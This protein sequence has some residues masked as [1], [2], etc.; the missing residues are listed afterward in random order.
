MQT[1]EREITELEAKVLNVIPYGI[2]NAT[3]GY[4]LRQRLNG[5]SERTFH[6]IIRSLRMKQYPIGATRNIRQ[7]GYFIMQ[8]EEERERSLQGLRS[9]TQSQLELIELIENMKVG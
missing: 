8:N 6:D 3:Q 4:I 2:E 9:Q 7:S 1:T 5:L